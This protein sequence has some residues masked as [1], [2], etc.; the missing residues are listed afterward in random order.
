[1]TLAGLAVGTADTSLPLLFGTVHIHCGEAY[2][3]K[4]YNHENNIYHTKH[5]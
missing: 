4:Y 2:Q 3:S 5:V 1:M